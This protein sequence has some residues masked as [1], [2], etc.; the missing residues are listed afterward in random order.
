MCTFAKFKHKS[1]FCAKHKAPA[2][3]PTFLNKSGLF[4][5]LLTKVTVNN[6]DTALFGDVRRL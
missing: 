5:K 2:T 4:T 3:K 6:K 1:V